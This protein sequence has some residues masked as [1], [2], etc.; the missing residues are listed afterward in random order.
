LT[1]DDGM[2]WTTK[3]S[4]ILAAV[5]FLMHLCPCVCIYRAKVGTIFWESEEQ[6]GLHIVFSSTPLVLISWNSCYDSPYN[7]HGYCFLPF[8]IL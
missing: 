8:L 2:G 4:E 1:T 3:I 7:T 5:A 6:P